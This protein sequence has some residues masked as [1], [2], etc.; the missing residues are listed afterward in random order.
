MALPDRSHSVQGEV[1]HSSALYLSLPQ[2]LAPQEFSFLASAQYT[3]LY[4]P[5]KERIL[6]FWLR[7]SYD[8]KSFNWKFYLFSS[9]ESLTYNYKPL[10]SQQYSYQAIKHS[11]ATNEPQLV[12]SLIL[13]FK[14]L[15]HELLVS[16]SCP[17]MTSQKMQVVG[18]G[19]RV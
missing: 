4:T 15:K 19:L 17:F 12:L 2:F 6:K 10:I 3:V 11:K 1:D 13:D 7:K 18:Q 8:E 14:S 9:Q 5:N 16:L